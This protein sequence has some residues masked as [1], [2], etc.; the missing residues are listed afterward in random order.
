SIRVVRNARLPVDGRNVVHDV[1]AVHGGANRSRVAD[2]AEREVHA[3]L[4]KP[5]GATLVTHEGADPMTPGREPAREV[6]AGKARGA[7]YE[8]T[9]G[10]ATRVTGEPKTLRRPIRSRTS[11]VQTVR[12]RDR[13]SL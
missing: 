5:R 13:R 7:G 4:G 1:H 6:A 2:V 12:R 3:G 8:I 10:A 9:R 11:S